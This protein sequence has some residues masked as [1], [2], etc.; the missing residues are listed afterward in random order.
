MLTCGLLQHRCDAEAYIR[1]WLHNLIVLFSVEEM[2]AFFDSLKQIPIYCVHQTSIFV[3]VV[4]M[5]FD[6]Y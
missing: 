3:A 5:S 2:L 1:L 6:L 4:S